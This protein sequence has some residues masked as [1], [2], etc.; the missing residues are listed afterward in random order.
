MGSIARA[1]ARAYGSTPPLHNVPREHPL[2]ERKRA[3]LARSAPLWASRASPPSRPKAAPPATAGRAL[4]ERAHRD[5]REI[6]ENPV[7]SQI[8]EPLEFYLYFDKDTY[9]LAKSDAAPRIS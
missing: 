3:P 5:I 6:R 4:T 8:A 9:L 7:D 1:E 2:R